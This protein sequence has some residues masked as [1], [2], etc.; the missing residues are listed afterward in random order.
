MR[1]IKKVAI[2]GAGTMGASIAL[3][4][5]NKAFD[6]WIYD[7]SEKQL[8]L[9]KK[10]IELNLESLVKEEILSSDE[11]SMTMERIQFSTNINIFE[12]VEFVSESI[13]EKLEIKQ[14]FWKS[15]S[16]I[17]KPEAILTTNTSGLSI[18]AIA[19]RVTDRSRFAGFHWVNPPHLVPFVEIIKGNETTDEVAEA[20]RNISIEIG[21]KPITVKKD[22]PGFALNRIQFA[23]LR[24]SM[25]IVEQGI[26][27][28]E[29]VDTL[30]KY[31]LGL[32]YALLGP[33]ETADLGG[34]DVFYAISSYLFAELNADKEPSK[35]L[36]EI[37]EAGNYGAKTGKGF[38]DYTDG[39]KE[40]IIKNRD[41]KLL[42]MMK[43]VNAD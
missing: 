13:V 8:E 39:R 14:S 10:L 22:V 43:Y 35:L 17:A 2:A 18:N 6:V 28:A 9:G 32:R 26:A 37:V 23:V 16:E 29:D 11:A 34:L 40:E 20:I 27:S 42:K 38:Y 5:A 19:E 25:H 24:E 31:G 41:E 30:L 3:C 21:K 12:D 33:F 1:E 15:I 36:K 4:F 7:L